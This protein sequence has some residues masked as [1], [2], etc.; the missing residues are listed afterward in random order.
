GALLAKGRVLG[1]QFEALFSDNLYQR[2]GAPA[3]EYAA[4]IRAALVEG[5][6][7]LYCDAPTNQ[8][9]LIVEDAAMARLAEKVEFSFWERLDASH[10]VIRLA[11]SWA[12]QAGDVQ[13]LCALL[14]DF[15]GAV[16]E[17][18]F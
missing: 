13:R 17:Q 7:K 14:R 3:V 12:T 15:Q 1:I 11:T 8:V 5:G 10:C 4:Q 9:F 16:Q 2:I 18:L 6:F